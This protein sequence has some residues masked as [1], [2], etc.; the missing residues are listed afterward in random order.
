MLQS[1][2]YS[3]SPLF[4]YSD[5]VVD[6]F[7]RHV[8]TTIPAKE[9]ETSM[10]NYIPVNNEAHATKRWRRYESYTFAASESI[11]PLVAAEL[12]RVVAAFPIAFIQRNSAFFPV[13]LLGLEQ[14][15]NLFVAANGQWV[16][17]YVPSALRGHPF[18]LA[19]TEDNKLVLCV[20]QDSGLITDGPEGEPFFDESGNPSAS[21]AQ[22]MDFLQQV[23]GNRQATA[24]MCTVLAERGLIKSW[25]ITLKTP[26]G[27]KSLEGLF[28]VDEQAMNQLP[29]EAF[30]E[31]R[32][33]G[34][35][36]MAYCQLL[37]MQHLASLGK[38]AEA[39][40]HAAAQ[41]DQ[42]LHGLIRF[43]DDMIKFT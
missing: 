5:V 19:H 15:R 26:E 8:V 32:Q 20:D 13:A 39:H 34:V 1:C 17:A 14:G 30:L 12:P 43:D 11:L 9:K 23:E 42:S 41:Q 33:A 22:I 18:R 2:G 25:S 28:Q 4:E 40:A 38:L 27:D 3:A 10:P 29:G 21:V 35:L 36:P 16:G 24:R 6:W 7:P 31:L 37:S